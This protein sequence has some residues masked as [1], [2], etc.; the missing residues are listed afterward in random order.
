MR[1]DQAQP[2]PMWSYISPE[3]RMSTVVISSAKRCL[4]LFTAVFHGLLGGEVSRVNPIA[5]HLH[6]E[7]FIVDLE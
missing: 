2:A 4:E 5:L 6:M 7:R 3:Q 1:G